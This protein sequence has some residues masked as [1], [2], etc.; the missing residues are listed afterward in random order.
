MLLIASKPK[1]CA[2]DLSDMFNFMGVL[3]VAVKPGEIF[4][5]IPEIYRAILLLS[6]E[7]IYDEIDFS[8]KIRSY[9]KNIPIFA[10][11]N[12]K[13]ECAF[14]AVFPENLSA[15]EIFHTVYSFCRGSGFKAPGEYFLDE[16]DASPE[17]SGAVCFSKKLPLTK[18]ELMILRTLLCLYPNPVKP[19]EIIK[20]AF[21]KKRAPNE[22][23]VRTHIS[24]INKKAMKILGRKLILSSEKQ[25]Y[26]IQQKNQSKLFSRVET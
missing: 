10:F 21:R 15:A 20:F 18:T 17:R 2:E 13:T 5:E 4:D 19:S 7:K 8:E 14:D 12:A 3:S 23:S 26:Y 6:P 24:I 11:G 1:E 25:G 9:Y 22:T 16:I